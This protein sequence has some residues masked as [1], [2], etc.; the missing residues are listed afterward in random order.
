MIS[1]TQPKALS[2]EADAATPG[3]SGIRKDYLSFCFFS[4]LLILAF[5]RPLRDLIGFSLNNQLFSHIILIPFIS[6]YLV[7]QKRLQ[8]PFPKKHFSYTALVF[9]LVG[10]LAI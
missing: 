4:M 3:P 7:W 8:L 5:A 9:V 10:I 2:F 1:G 6:A